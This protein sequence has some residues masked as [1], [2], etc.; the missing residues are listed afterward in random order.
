MTKKY[1]QLFPEQRYKIAPLIE[2][3][4]CK[5]EIALI[6]GVHKSTISK[7]TRRNVPEWG[8][9]ANIYNAKKAQQK[10]D[11]RHSKKTY[12]HNL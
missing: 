9:G 3:G 2:A 12:A 1:N 11:L 6:V 8:I 5:S 4:I 7:E 10:T